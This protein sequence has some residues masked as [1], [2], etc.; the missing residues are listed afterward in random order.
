MLESAV[1]IIHH[2]TAGDIAYAD[3]WLKEEI[4]GYLPNTTISDGY[5]VYESLLNHYYDEITPLTS[6]KPYMVGPGNHEANCTFPPNT[7]LVCMLNFCQVTMAVQ[8]I[9]AI[10]SP[11]QLTSA[12]LVRPIL[13]VIS[14]I[15]VCLVLNQG[16]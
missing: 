7:S 13:P 15:S 10:T 2:M 11:T 1:L 16:D 8:P 3:Y 6:V 4:Q 12:Y 9:R 5:K 14:T